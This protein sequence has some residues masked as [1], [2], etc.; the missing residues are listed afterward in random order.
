MED[1]GKL[2]RIIEARLKLKARF[3]QQMKSHATGS[4]CPAQSFGPVQPA[5]YAY[6]SNWAT[7]TVK[8]PVPDLGYGL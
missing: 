4:G 1:P 6:K 3:E 7:K 8:W 2:E 5:W